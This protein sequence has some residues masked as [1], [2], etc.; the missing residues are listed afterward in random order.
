VLGESVC[1]CA[2]DCFAVIIQ[3]EFRNEISK[4]RS[5]LSLDVVFSQHVTE[6]DPG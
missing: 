3:L 1:S 2:V 4:V 6:F 5:V